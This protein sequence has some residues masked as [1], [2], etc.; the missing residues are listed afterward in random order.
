MKNWFSIGQFS[1]KVSLTERT[2][3]VYEAAG[4]IQAHTRGENNYRY[5]TEDQIEVVQ[6]IKQ[7][8]SFGF[9]LAEI[10]SLLEVDISM[11]P[12]KLQELLEQRLKSIRMDQR[13]LQLA[14]QKIQSILSS[15]KSNN[16]GL[17][18][19]ERKFIMN[20][21][22]KVGVVVAGLN[23]LELTAQY[24]NKHI[25]SAG[26]NIPV[27][28][29]DG[30]SLLPKMKP[31]IV[32]IPEQHLNNLAVQQLSPD[33]VVIKELSASSKSIHS[34]Y[35]QL[36]RAVSP[37]MST[38]LN[39]DDRAVIE[40]AAN[41]TLRKG[42]TFYF[43]KNLA[44]QPQISQIGGVISRGESIQIF[45]MNQYAEPV[46]LKMSRSTEPVELK[47]SR[48]LG[49]IEEMAFLASLAAVMNLGLNPENLTD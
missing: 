23:G 10:K 22:E 15:L 46:E 21:L 13:Q 20:Q 33:I 47:M 25:Q 48:I 26:K 34:N 35:L 28:L 4:L 40:L 36:Y 44:L 1:K 24:I 31:Y 14:E 3:R 30:K 27:T 19:N 12:Q 16:K 32:I 17:N 49:Q 43:S 38:I 42:K 8:K 41:E 39:A 37:Q 45:G 11:D 5:F 18:P 7:F 2:L 6:R 9:K 29:W